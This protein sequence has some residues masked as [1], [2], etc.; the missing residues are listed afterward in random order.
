MENDLP[1]S[2]ADEFRALC[3]AIGFVVVNWAVIEQQIDN[4]VNV[5]FINCGGKA[6]RKSGDIPRSLKQKTD[7]LQDCFKKLLPLQ[8]FA[9]EGRDLL[10]RVNS[11]STKRHDLVHGAVMSLTPVNGSFQ[12]RVVGYERENHTATEF[13]FHPDEF[14]TLGGLLGDLLTELIA[15]SQKL[16]KKFLV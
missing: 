11:L 15:F 16:A 6:L 4:L 3:M 2:E 10:G 1:K 13:T 9:D 5:A 7:F 8:P 12:F 14:D